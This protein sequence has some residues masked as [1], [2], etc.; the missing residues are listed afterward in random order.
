MSKLCVWV[1]FYI[2]FWVLGVVII[3]YLEELDKEGDRKE[4]VSGGEGL[5]T[6][7]DGSVILWCDAKMVFVG[8]G[9][10]ALFYPTL[11]YNVVRNK[12]QSEFRWWDWVDE[13]ELF[14]LLRFP[15]HYHN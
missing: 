1:G 13:V 3:M 11:L 6:K 10:R 8:A 2:V 12:I 14:V 9:A 7:S 4:V 15:A 5:L